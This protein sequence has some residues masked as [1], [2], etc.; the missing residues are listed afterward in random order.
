MLT[1]G[2]VGLVD[3]LSIYIYIYL[4]GPETHFLLTLQEI[5]D[6]AMKILSDLYQIRRA[7][8]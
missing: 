1:L 6:F 8:R 4:T 5:S 7:K 3:M 2:K